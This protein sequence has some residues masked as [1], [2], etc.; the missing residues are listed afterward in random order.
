MD[1]GVESSP[2]T[3]VVVGGIV[4]DFPVNDTVSF[5]SPRRIPRKLQKRLLEAKTPTTSSVEE[6]EAK[7]RHAHLR[8]QVPF[9]FLFFFTYLFFYSILAFYFHD[10]R[11]QRFN[12]RLN[13]YS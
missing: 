11:E 12:F 5:S 13:S 9:Y 4:L 2:E 1:T 10:Q 8:R 7:L 6:I 3:G